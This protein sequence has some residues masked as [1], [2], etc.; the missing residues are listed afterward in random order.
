MPFLGVGPASV[1]ASIPS[2]SQDS[3]FITPRL[4]LTSTVPIRRV[5]AVGYRPECREA[6]SA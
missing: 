3:S 4:D 5:V 1:S 2:A 6:W